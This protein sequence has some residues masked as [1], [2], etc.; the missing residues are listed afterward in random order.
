VKREELREAQRPLKARYRD[1]PAAARPTASQ[2]I[3]GASILSLPVTSQS[4]RRSP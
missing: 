1:D 4:T 3:S 2:V